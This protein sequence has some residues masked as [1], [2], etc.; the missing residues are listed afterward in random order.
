MKGQ[1]KE[2][3][4]SWPMSLGEGVGVLAFYLIAW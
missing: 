4:D 2:K 1:T 3:L